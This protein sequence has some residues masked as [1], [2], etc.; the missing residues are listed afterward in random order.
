MPCRLLALCTH[1]AVVLPYKRADE[2]LTLLH[3]I[4]ALVSRRGED[5]LSSL[6]ASLQQ[7]Q[8]GGPEDQ[9]QGSAQVCFSLRDHGI[10]GLPG[11]AYIES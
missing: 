7:Q 6:R 1:L 2:P 9:Q 3:A 11:I 10:A 4:N 5:V 8:Q